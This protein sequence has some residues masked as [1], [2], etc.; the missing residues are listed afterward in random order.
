VTATD[1]TPAPS[2][3]T[4]VHSLQ[5]TGPQGLLGSKDG[6]RLPKACGDKSKSLT[7]Q[8]THRV[9][10]SDPPVIE[11]CAV[12]EDYVPNTNTKCKR[13][14]KGEVWEGTISGTGVNHDLPE[15]PDPSSHSGDFTVTVK[16]DGKATLTGHMVN[17]S[18]CVGGFTTETDFTVEGQKTRSAISFAPGAFPFDKKVDL[19]IRGDRASGTIATDPAGATAF[20]VNLD[21]T[22]ECQ[23]CGDEAV[24]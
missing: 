2:W 18:V 15:C 24:G 16:P 6:G 21:L 7:V 19:R 22:A 4:G 17:T 8:G 20:V 5:V 9:K 12:T 13:W 11:L 1:K 3:Q 14:Y 10:R 23:S